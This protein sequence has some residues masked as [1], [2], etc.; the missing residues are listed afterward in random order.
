MKAKKR[1]LWLALAVILL[2]G[3]G[4][5]G[6]FIFRS[7]APVV[8]AIATDGLDA[9]V[10]AAIN[11]ARVEV[12]AQPKSA[13]AWGRLGMVLFAHDRYTDCQAI[14]AEA[15]R[16]EPNNPRWPYF[17]GLATILQEPKEGIQLLE[18][19]ANLSPR[20]VTLRLRLAEQYLKLG[21]IN[22]ADDSFHHVLAEQPGNPRALLGIGQVM[23]QRSEFSQAIE[24]LKAAAAHPTAQKSARLALVQAYHGLGN[25]AAAE[26]EQLRASGSP[27]DVEWPDVFIA[28]AAQFRTGLH[29][30]IDQALSM[31][32]HEKFKEARELIANVLRDHPDSDEAHLTKA[33]ILIREGDSAGAQPEL[34][35]A[36]ELNPS[37]LDGHFLLGGVHT[38]H[39][40][41][42]KAE[43]CYLRTIELKPS[44]G[45]AHYNLGECRRKRG[46]NAK[47]IDAFLDAIRYRP[48]LAV[49]H[50][51]IGEL[52]LQDAKHEQAIPHLENALR[53]DETNDQARKLLEQ[54]RAKT[55]N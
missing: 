20:S 49:A 34:L 53:L 30:R 14:F 7:N 10:V 36:L 35:R 19:A 21:R 48:D 44:H 43:K 5:A 39:G 40:D 18:R 12:E 16:L 22:E 38:L 47:A 46:D 29:P 11:T 6:Y 23:V 32:Q 8:P 1:G 37:L 26:T 2:A 9:E 28:E 13:A 55:K 24:P 4:T 51:A 41:F 25:A 33:K 54:A 3:A 42:E 15:E 52:L 17:R 27:P 45:L 31:M 50:L